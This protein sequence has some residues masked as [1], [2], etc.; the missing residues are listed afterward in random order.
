VKSVPT[1]GD[2]EK[3]RNLFKQNCAV[4]HRLHGEGIEIGPDLAMVSGKPDEVLL[5]AVL[6]PNQAVEARYVSYNVATKNGRE[7]SGIIS[8]ET[9]TSLTL[10]SQGG[11]EEVLLRG[12]IAELRSSGVSLMPEGLENVLKPTDMADL[13]AFVRS[14]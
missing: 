5:A 12:D 6:D 4:C 3:G 8:A 14:K 11:T 1:A 9:A 7:L 2:A 10:R 13:L